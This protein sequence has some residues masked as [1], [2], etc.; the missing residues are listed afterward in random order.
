[1]LKALNPKN[2]TL[3]NRAIAAHIRYNELNDLRN[4]A[5]DSENTKEYNKLDRMCAQVFDRYLDYTYQ[6][7]KGQQKAIETYIS[8]TY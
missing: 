2:Q 7:P 3:V 4:L 6:L 1:M 8:N 5:E